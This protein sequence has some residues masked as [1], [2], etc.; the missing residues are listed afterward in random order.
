[1]DEA[2][3]SNLDIQFVVLFIYYQL[4]IWIVD[5]APGLD[6][7]QRPNHYHIGCCAQTSKRWSLRLSFRAP[8]GIA[9]MR[10][11]G[12]GSN[13]STQR[14]QETVAES[15]TGFDGVVRLPR[16]GVGNMGQSSHK[17]L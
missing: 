7:K 3:V 11:I 14:D 6:N 1:M 5:G 9:F 4:R 12:Y 8:S 10:E 16:A 15:L 13:E 2:S 17:L